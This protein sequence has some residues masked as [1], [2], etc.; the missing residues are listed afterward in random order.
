MMIFTIWNTPTSETIFRICFVL[1]FGD[2]EWLIEKVYVRFTDII[3]TVNNYISGDQTKAIN[4][5]Q[6]QI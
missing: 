6:H 3:L 1:F 2:D 5:L 4:E